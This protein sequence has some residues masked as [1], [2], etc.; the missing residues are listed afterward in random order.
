VQQLALIEI[1]R[2]RFGKDPVDGVT[3]HGVSVSF[4]KDSSV[5]GGALKKAFKSLSVV[6]STLA[7]SRDELTRPLLSK[8]S[9]K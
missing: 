2:P 6:L 1:Y 3:F 4:A 9:P 7:F 8:A 5:G